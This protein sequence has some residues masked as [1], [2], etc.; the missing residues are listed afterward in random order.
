MSQ[1]A[2]RIHLASRSPRRRELL[3]QIGVGHE[4]L[5][6]RIKAARGADVNE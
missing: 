6:Q 4:V 1:L 2:P 5:T 3:H